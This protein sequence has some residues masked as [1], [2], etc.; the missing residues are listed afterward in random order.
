MIQLVKIFYCLTVQ[1]SWSV[2]FMF[3]IRT[4]WCWTSLPE[5]HLGTME[6]IFAI[7][8]FF[9][10]IYIVTWSKYHPPRGIGDNPIWNIYKPFSSY[11]FKMLFAIDVSILLTVSIPIVWPASWNSCTRF[12]DLVAWCKVRPSPICFGVNF[13]ALETPKTISC[14]MLFPLQKLQPFPK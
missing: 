2:N 9:E 11:L 12:S 8:C 13:L 14:A 7:N 4:L 5:H 10:N 6:S 1:C 3:I